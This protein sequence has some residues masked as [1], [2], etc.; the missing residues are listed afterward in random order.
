ME[1]YTLPK[2]INYQKNLYTTLGI[3]NTASLNNSLSQN[4]LETDLTNYINNNPTI[5]KM[6]SSG[7]SM[8]STI[9]SAPKNA[10]SGISLPINGNS[11]DTSIG[12][13]N[14]MQNPELKYGSLGNDINKL[15]SGQNGVRDAMLGGIDSLKNIQLP[16]NQPSYMDTY[17]G[18]ANK[19][20]LTEDANK[21]NE[22]NRTIAGTEGDIKGEVST[23]GGVAN[24][25]QLASLTAERAKPLINEY[26]ILKDALA[27]KTSLVEKLM[28]Y[29]QMDRAEAEKQ[30]EMKTNLNEK[31]IDSY[32][33]VGQAD[34]A[35]VNSL[36]AYDNN[37]KTLAQNKLKILLESGG[38]STLPDSSLGK[39]SVDTG[40]D[41]A[42][43]RAAS[44]NTDI[45][46]SLKNELTRAQITESYA[47]A[48][49]DKAAI[50]PTN[51]TSPQVVSLV[52]NINNVLADPNL[53]AASGISGALSFPG[54]DTRNTRNQ[55]EQI[56]NQLKVENRAQLKGQGQITEGE[57][58]MLASAST[59][60]NS[61]TSYGQTVA[62]L[63]KIKGTVSLM[64]GIPA[65]VV[66][67]A[68]NGTSAETTFTN[69]N[70]LS[71]VVK[72]GGK[73][74]FK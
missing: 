15:L 20:N 49:K 62:E 5:G 31:I 3:G 48:A 12:A 68:P 44:A 56:K 23:A 72:A 29:G 40:I 51:N 53:N 17:A 22:L 71:E 52:N 74:T 26:N 43:L 58:A 45:A 1:G 50:I 8:P 16:T 59:A 47:S 65:T 14:N 10:P 32:S 9:A 46:N 41:I 70:Q 35:T 11:I 7:I 57:Q 25:S 13:I 30:I 66:I 24:A 38:L 4:R 36:M 67:T 64:N 39:L 63:Q 60:L 55:V 54:T 73:Y 19:Y 18:L 21:L 27:T 6:L 2:D 34:Q 61:A 37:Q 42:T 69:S 28:Q 33:K